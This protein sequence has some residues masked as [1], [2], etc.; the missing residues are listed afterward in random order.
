M[1]TWR[2]TYTAELAQKRKMRDDDMNIEELPEKKKGRPLA[3]GNELD[4]Q[5]KKYILHLRDK[6]AVVNTAIVQACAEG[7]VKNHDKRLLA[8]NGG[9]IMLTR[10]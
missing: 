10:D 9:H 4:A 2:N 3:L 1:R 7:I 5:V 6:G 8:L